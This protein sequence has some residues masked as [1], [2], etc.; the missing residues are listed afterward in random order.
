MTQIAPPPKFSATFV[1]VDGFTKPAGLNCAAVVIKAFGRKVCGVRQIVSG[2]K[3]KVLGLAINADVRCPAVATMTVHAHQSAFVISM[4]ATLIF[5][6]NALHNIAQ[7]DKPIVGTDAVDMV[8]GAYRPSPRH[9][10]PRKPMS[11]V[12]Q[13]SDTDHDVPMP[14]NG[15][16]NGPGRDVAPATG[17]I[18]PSEQPSVGIV[19]E[20]FA[21]ALCG[22]IVSS[23]DAVLRRVVRGSQ[24]FAAP[25]GPC[26]FRGKLA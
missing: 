24:A 6:V 7:V 13:P 10:Q 12:E 18:A 4:R 21:Q 16:H 3:T 26:H 23:H 5:C 9:V 19:V 11:P 17:C 20:Q 22:K 1:D 15:A 8:Q 14:M 2:I 25:R